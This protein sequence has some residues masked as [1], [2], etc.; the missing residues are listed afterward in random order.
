MVVREES[1]TSAVLRM[2]ATGAGMDAVLA[3]AADKL[4]TVGAKVVTAVDGDEILV[5]RRDGTDGTA[6]TQRSRSDTALP[7]LLERAIQSGAAEVEGACI[8]LPA[9]WVVEMDSADGAAALLSELVSLS[10][11]VALCRRCHRAETERDALRA[12]PQAESAQVNRRD[13][14]VELMLDQAAV[15]IALMGDDG[16][17]IR[18]NRRLC[19]ILGYEEDEL[20]RS[21]YQALSPEW[22]TSDADA[23][24]QLID[25][26]LRQLVI[27]KT[28]HRKNGDVAWLRVAISRTACAAERPS[29]LAVIEDITSQRTAEELL[30]ESEERLRLLVEHAPAAIALFDTKMRYL[31]VSNR[32][33]TDY[34]IKGAS[35]LGRSYYELFPALPRHW[36]KVHERCLA[37]AVERSDGE[38]FAREDGGVEWVRWELRPWKTSTGTIGGLVLFSEVITEQR[39]IAESLSHS[40]QRYRAIFE[41]AGIGIAS[42][43]AETGRFL[44]VNEQMA[45]VLGY[46]RAELQQMTWE[47]VTHPDDVT[48]HR[49]ALFD[50]FERRQVASVTREK[51]YVRKDGETRWG[52]VTI[53]KVGPDDHGRVAYV[54]MIEDE[55]QRRNMVEAL[56]ESEKR[57]ALVLEASLTG[58]AIL[59]LDDHVIV[60]ASASITHLTGYS[61]REL[62]GATLES[63]ELFVD[64]AERARLWEE[65]TAAREALEIRVRRKAGDV[66]H[67]VV[68]TCP[69]TIGGADCRVV[70]LNDVSVIRRQADALAQSERE[71]RALFDLAPVG[72]AEQDLVTG[73]MLRVNGRLATITGFTV[74]EL[75]A[76]A[77]FSTLAHPDDREATEAGI[78]RLVNGEIE[79]LRQEKRLIRKDGSTAWV[80]MVMSTSERRGGQATRALAIFE[81]IAERRAAEASLRIFASALQASANAVVITDPT[82]R[83]ESI[84]PAFTALTGYSEAD[85]IGRSPRILKSGR[86][87]TEFYRD[88]WETVSRGDVWRGELVNRRKDGELYHEDMTI[89]PL[90]DSRGEISH[91]IAIKQDI[92]KRRQADA[93]LRE[94]EER[95]RDLVDSLD[96]LVYSTDEQGL[97][98]FVSAACRRF[99][100][101]PEQLIG[102]H[103]AEVVHPDD[104]EIALQRLS[105][106]RPDEASAEVRVF[107]AAG[108]VRYVRFA[109]RMKLVDGVFRGTTGLLVD[110]TARRETEEQLRAAQKMEAIGRLAGGVAHDFNNILSVILS[111]T[112]LAVTDLRPEDPLHADLSQVIEAAHRAEGLTRQLLAFSR[113]QVLNPE[114]LDL[115]DVVAALDKMLHRLIGED[116]ELVVTTTSHLDLVRADRGQLEQ[117][118]M[119]LVVNARDAMP[120]GGAIRIATSNVALDASRASA[121]EV[122][123]GRYVELLFSDNGCGMDPSVLARIFEPFFTTKG[124]GKGTGLGLSMVYGIIRQSDGAIEATSEPGRGTTFKIYLPKRDGEHSS[125]TFRAVTA[126]P[127][128]GHEVILVVEDEPALRNVIR[129]V[130]AATGYQVWVAANAGEALLLCEKNGRSVRLILTDVVMPGMSGRELTVRL[131]PLCPSAKVIYMSGY[132]DE[133]IE[134]HG[135]LG[136][137]FLRKP[138]DWKTLTDRVRD[139][140]DQRPE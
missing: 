55:T 61:R 135:V 95:Y 106:Q 88:L 92:S 38:P 41:N 26:T 126:R 137:E 8:A 97:I 21:R 136:A 22:A 90:R 107:D 86:Q 83:I 117:V 68:R 113:R 71:L 49:N 112:E 47:D 67:F 114:T 98:T 5:A 62:I 16:R 129:R 82:G 124:V 119:N 6:R 102:K 52:K 75:G 81:D 91:F 66:G 10:D 51:R 34:G 39:R 53:S 133:A 132:T 17:F 104:R 85:V 56:R 94:S 30:S 28:A 57:L 110:V 128:Q 118:L 45:A 40:E 120:E 72:L 77:G 65:P 74:E 134:R 103:A 79:E 122:T 27:E 121:L 116:I 46:S 4:L 99:G 84:N 125:T 73:R 37:G 23:H 11:A 42:V 80:S 105:G 123:P 89:T 130:L 59:R 44:E 127:R 29:F 24:R 58:M 7:A 9:G 54:K 12:Q 63:L 48:D 100:Y 20:R 50:A 69:L 109:H 139:T 25:G 31:G 108:K 35:I 2:A 32:Y 111:Y 138:F 115:N 1:P 15:G 19:E 14:P 101:S 76:L 36:L 93:A 43:E 3:A 78:S 87:S 140:L 13:G 33:L 60:D 64:A 96:D 70:A 131:A 18:V